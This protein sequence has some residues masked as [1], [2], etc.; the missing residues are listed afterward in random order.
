MYDGDIIDAHH[1]LWDLEENHYP[2]LTPNPE[3]DPFPNF[4]DL[5][6]NYLLEDF[7]A[8][9]ANQNIVKSVHVQAE[10][11]EDDPVRETAWLQKI[12]DDPSSGGCL[13]TGMR[14]IHSIPAVCAAEPGVV[15]ALDPLLGR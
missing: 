10:H 6:Q 14:A 13:A 1:H 8:D 5:C 15:S 3:T 4:A 7:R 11:D 9:C 2:W 12:A